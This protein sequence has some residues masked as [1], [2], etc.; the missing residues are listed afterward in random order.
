MAFVMGVVTM[1]KVSKNMPRKA[2]AYHNLHCSD[3]VVDRKAACEP[4]VPM[5]EYNAILKRLCELEEK[6]TI[7]GKKP[8]VPKRRKTCSTLEYELA[9]TKKVL[10]EASSRQEELLAYIEKKKKKKNRTLF[11]GKWWSKEEEI[12]A[13][14][15]K[16]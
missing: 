9:A 1:M 12:A 2:V 10:N 5:S 15:D 13:A 7:L 16:H 4:T 3:E 14:S 8:E 6:V 11:A